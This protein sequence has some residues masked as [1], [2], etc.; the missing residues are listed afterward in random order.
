MAT[1]K[2]L[3]LKKSIGS[4]KKTALRKKSKNP[5]NTA[6]DRADRALQDSYRR[7]YPNEK[8]EVCGGKFDLMHHH[9]EKSNSMFARWMQPKNLIF[10]C[11]ECHQAI[12]FGNADP[13]GVYSIGR[14]VYWMNEIRE[15]RKQK[16]VHKFKKVGNKLK[17]F[18]QGID[19]EEYYAN[20][21]PEK[22]VNKYAK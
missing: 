3:I 11:K 21:K 19:L 10:I 16:P 12:H 4:M 22:W 17:V 2:I 6:K 1:Q 20:N 15:M 5:E 14:S 7:N 9:I 13:V 18:Y 8:C